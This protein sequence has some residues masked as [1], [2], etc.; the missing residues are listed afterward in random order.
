[1]RSSID[2]HNYLQSLGVQHELVTLSDHVKGTE[3]LAD[4]LDLEPCS[5]VKTL[6]FIAD[7]QPVLAMVPGDKRADTR[8]L[9]K[10]L[11]A[12]RLIP[13]TEQEV[14]EITG[15]MVTALPPVAFKSSVTAIA[16][17]SLTGNNIVYAAGGNPNIVLKLRASDLVKAT[18][19]ALADICVAAR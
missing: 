12:A 13:A 9:K 2:V 10:H 4:L 16:D 3:R 8:K 19:A 7:G 11:S 5:V 15:F 17:H 18:K 6:V 1:M 14:F